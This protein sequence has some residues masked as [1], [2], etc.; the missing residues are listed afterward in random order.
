MCVFY[1]YNKGVNIVFN[2]VIQILV[3]LLNYLLIGL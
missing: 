2:V 1:L 3:L